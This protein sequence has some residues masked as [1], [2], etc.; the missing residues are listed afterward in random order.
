LKSL[1]RSQPNRKASIET[2]KRRQTYERFFK[3]ISKRR[4]TF[5]RYFMVKAFFRKKL[6]C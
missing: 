3:K 4:K 1:P 2:S 6:I 5:E